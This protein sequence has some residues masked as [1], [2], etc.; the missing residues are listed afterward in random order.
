[1]GTARRTSST[2]DA[3]MVTPAEAK[4]RPKPRGVTGGRGGG[5]G[6]GGAA[7]R[8][9]PIKQ[10]T[11]PHQR[12]KRNSSTESNRSQQQHNQVVKCYGYWVDAH[13]SI[14]KCMQLISQH[15]VEN[16]VHFYMYSTNRY[17][18]QTLPRHHR[19][20]EHHQLQQ[21]Q[22]QHLRQRD[23][24][25]G[26]GGSSELEFN[27]NGSADPLLQQQRGQLSWQGSP[28]TTSHRRR[29]NLYEGLSSRQHHSSYRYIHT[30]KYFCPSIYQKYIH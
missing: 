27:N 22:Q 15:D 5:G 24:S 30:S 2:V 8:E 28:R 23:N 18:L 29:S 6:G 20:R 4:K 25:G 11:L 26:G 10:N 17:L 9:Q 19:D 7:E 1:M 16:Y 12:E 3:L 21:Q 13:D 14:R